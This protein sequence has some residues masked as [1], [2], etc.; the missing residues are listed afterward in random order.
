M[1][2]GVNTCTG[3]GAPGF[4]YIYVNGLNVAYALSN[5][6]ACDSASALVFRNLNVGDIA[7]ATCGDNAG[8][9]VSCT[10][11]LINL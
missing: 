3:G 6:Y 7:M 5:A 8:R 10:F 1:H 11:T 2:A 4:V 9:Y